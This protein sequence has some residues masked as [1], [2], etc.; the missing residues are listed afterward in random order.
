[1]AVAV[2]KT[3]L[4]TVVAAMRTTNLLTAVEATEVD[5]TT[6]RSILTG[7]AVTATAEMKV[8]AM[9]KVAEDTDTA[10]TMVCSSVFC[11]LGICAN[12][13]LCKNEGSS[14]KI[15][16]K[17]KKGSKSDSSDDDKKQRKY[18]KESSPDSDD[19]I[20]YKKKQDSGDSDEEKRYK[21]ELKKAEKKGKKERKDHDSSDDD[22]DSDDKKKQKKYGKK[23]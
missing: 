3:N 8:A 9:V 1:M 6:K 21:K 11:P 16:V 20:R 22:S 15:K 13:L 23:Y 14:Q 17:D 18:K 12:M 4:L 2:T 10:G 19:E 7:E 5:M